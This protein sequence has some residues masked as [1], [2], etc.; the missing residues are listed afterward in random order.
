M[1][2]RL[3]QAAAVTMLALSGYFL[4]LSVDLMAR[5]PPKVAAAL[6][7]ALVGFALLSSATTL[8]K[9]LAAS[10]AGGGG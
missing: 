4:V 6:L 9:A 7:A 8:F 1:A 10:R 3:V 2:S 5:S